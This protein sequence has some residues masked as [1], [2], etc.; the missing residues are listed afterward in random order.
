[1]KRKRDSPTS[2]LVTIIYAPNAFCLNHKF[3]IN[4]VLNVIVKQG[5]CTSECKK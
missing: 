5:V 3:S 4:K 2:H 1:M